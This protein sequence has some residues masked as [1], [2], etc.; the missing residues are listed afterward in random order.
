MNSEVFQDD[1]RPCGGG[2]FSNIYKGRIVHP[3]G[4]V[5]RVIIKFPRV[6]IDDPDDIEDQ[7]R[8]V[9]RE[10]KAWRMVKPHDN[11][12][13]LLQIWEADE[14]Y[15]PAI[16]TPYC[17]SGCVKDFLKSNLTVDRLAIAKG[18]CNGLKH[19]HLNDIVHGDLTPVFTIFLPSSP[20]KFSCFGLTQRNVLLDNGVPR[21]CD[22]GRA[23]VMTMEGFTASIVAGT[24]R[25]MAPELIPSDEDESIL[26]EEVKLPKVTF[27][28]DVYAFSM[29]ALEVV[30]GK[31][32]FFYMPSE[33]QVAVR[34]NLGERPARDRYQVLRGPEWTGFWALLQ[35]CWDKNPASRPPI[36]KIVLR[37]PSNPPSS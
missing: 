7:T 24:I 32:P 16:L 20:E 19:L 23:R 11:I 31:S 3:S 22:F 15:P 28:S 37:L 8:R 12:L 13:P 21:L 34:L 26:P 17:P 14:R 1:I 33:Q 2:G 6:K 4:Q 29:L 30:A 27:E 36:E 10:Y 35:E 5:E 25:Y 18:I 9:H